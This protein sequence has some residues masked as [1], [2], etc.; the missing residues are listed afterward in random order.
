MAAGATVAAD[1]ALPP[2]DPVVYASRAVR[3][4]IARK[5]DLEASRIV[6]KVLLLGAMGV[7]KRHGVSH[8]NLAEVLRDYA[9]S[10]ETEGL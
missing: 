2:D 5:D 9:V 4:L 3:Y 8:A 6:C 7:L 1:D 10:I